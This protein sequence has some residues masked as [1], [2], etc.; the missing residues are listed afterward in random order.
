HLFLTARAGGAPLVK[1]T[2]FGTAKLMREAVA[3]TAGG[4]L[5]ATAMFGLSPYSS[6]ELLRKAK[7]VDARTDV[8]SLGAILYELL[9]GRAPFQGDTMRLMLSIT[10]EDPPPPSQLRSD[11]TPEIDQIISWALAKDVDA[12]FKN[13]LAFAQTLQPYAPPEG[14]VLIERIRQIADAAK[15]KRK[16]GSV[17]PPAFPSTRPPPVTTPMTAVNQALANEE[18]VTDIRAGMVD[19]PPPAAARARSAPPPTAPSSKSVAA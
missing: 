18:S 2:D 14:Q 9:T 13:V 4:D 12:R 10:K 17:P 8:W 5:T 15:S 11:L 7:G 16:G 3:P 6:P 19:A 1:I